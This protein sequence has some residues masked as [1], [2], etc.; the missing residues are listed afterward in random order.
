[1]C[2]LVG[3]LGSGIIQADLKIL[4][5]L[6]YISALRGTDGSGI[7]QGRFENFGDDQAKIERWNRYTIEK[8]KHDIAFFLWYSTKH[9]EGNKDLF[10]GI[11]NN[12]FG[13]HV[14]AATQG[15]ICAENSHPFEYNNL[16]GMHN[17]TLFDK[18]YDSKE[19]T[20]SELLIKDIS[21][22]GII[23][24]LKELSPNSAYALVMVDKRNGKVTFVRNN[25]RGLFCC[26]NAKR[27]V[28]Y[29]ASEKWMLEGVLARN[30]ET[31]Y[32]N[33]AYIFESFKVHSLYIDEFKKGT[34]RV[35]DELTAFQPK[36]RYIHC[37]T[38]NYKNNYDRISWNQKKENQKNDGKDTRREEILALPAPKKPKLHVS[39]RIPYGTCID[40]KKKLNLVDQFFARKFP[41]EPTLFICK[42]CDDSILKDDA[43]FDIMEPQE[44]KV[45]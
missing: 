40:C 10:D 5:E 28:M 43:P 31:I 22:N 29:W 2:G 23:P 35:F 24:V 3:I 30:G 12:F 39:G 27:D 11:H 7:V 8:S 6:S 9:P 41:M 36:E 20:D 33:T 21:E 1:M 18:K 38:N 13:V 34:D 15:H 19:Q 17:G 42:S 45:G 32:D 26:Y 16:I 4:R 37:N 14:R 25:D 44:V